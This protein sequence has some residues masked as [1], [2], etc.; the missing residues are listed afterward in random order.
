VTSAD[1]PRP[2]SAPPAPPAA[3]PA[4]VLVIFLLG[5]FVTLLDLTIVNVAI[6]AMASG[7]GS[8]LDQVL[9]VLS[10]YSIAYAVLLITAGRL[11]DIVGPKAMFVAGMAVFTAASAGS[12]AARSVGL[13]IAFRALQG[14]GAAMLAP[15][16][17]PLF[18]SVLPPERRGGAFAAMGAMSGLAVLAGPTL[19][20][21]IVT[22]WGWRWIFYVNVPIGVL[23]IALALVLLPDLRPGRRHRLDASGVA[24]LTLGLSGVVFGLVEGE[25]YDWGVVGAGVTIREIVAAGVALIVAFLWLQSRA[26][27]SEPLLPFEIFR[28]RNFG[29]MTAVLG[30]VGFA[31][32]GL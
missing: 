3:R 12:G 14:V 21:L 15:Q 32:V 10:A 28:N 11:G 27:R 22:S 25:R 30:C 23:T 16:G 4:A 29:L 17:L 2:G 1:T 24:L 26:Q 7:L 8:S 20:G 18:T 5:L 6:P 19:G 31:M 9:W 13:L